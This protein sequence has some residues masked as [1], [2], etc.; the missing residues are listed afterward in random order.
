MGIYYLIIDAKERKKEASLAI[1]SKF[2]NLLKKY[3]RK[4]SYEDAEQDLTCYFIELI[5]F[6][7]IEMF[8][9]EDE[10]KIVGY[11]TKCIYH[12]Y[13]RLLKQLIKRNRIISFS[14]LS[15]EQLLL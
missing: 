12:E 3:A 4:L 13:I 6:F 14:D 10:G 7:P 9:E 2:G 1:I 8:R 15:E 5:Y 11:I